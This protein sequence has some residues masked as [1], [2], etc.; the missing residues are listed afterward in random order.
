MQHQAQ[1][2]EW[3]GH[4]PNKSSWIG[5][6]LG[7]DGG[8]QVPLCPSPSAKE[9]HVNELGHFSHQ[10]PDPAVTAT[11]HEGPRWRAA[12]GV[13]F[14]VGQ[15]LGLLPS[16]S[17]WWVHFTAWEYFSRLLS[18]AYGNTWPPACGT[19]LPRR[20]VKERP[21]DVPIPILKAEGTGGS[22]SCIYCRSINTH[23]EILKQIVT[24]HLWLKNIDTQTH[25]VLSQN[26]RKTV[27]FMVPRDCIWLLIATALRD[28]GSGRGICYPQLVIVNKRSRPTCIRFLFF[29]LEFACLIQNS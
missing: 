12:T 10:G 19:A 11:H 20:W 21:P 25:T 29:F 24:C 27:L 22:G 6:Q 4:F 18:A 13:V 26:D 5:T 28:V 9:V 8:T 17:H 7:W 14:A 3:P 15:A 23:F 2:G 1:L 16:R